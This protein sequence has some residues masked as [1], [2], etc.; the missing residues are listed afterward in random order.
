MKDMKISLKKELLCI[1]QQDEKE[2][3]PE[4]HTFALMTPMILDTQVY[5]EKGLIED[6]S[7]HGIQ[8]PYLFV[9]T[10]CLGKLLYKVDPERFPISKYQNMK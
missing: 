9:E 10:V 5:T 6:L 3:Q 7:K 2:N 1:S 4:N 8:W